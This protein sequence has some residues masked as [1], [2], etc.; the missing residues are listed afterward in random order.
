MAAQNSVVSDHC[1]NT[2]DTPLRASGY[3]TGS[4]CRCSSTS[5]MRAVS[6]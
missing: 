3:S 2:R 1:A 4:G 5:Q 6:Q